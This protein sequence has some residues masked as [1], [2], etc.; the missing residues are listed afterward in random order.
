LSSQSQV[1][2]VSSPASSSGT[3]VKPKPSR[4]IGDFL[5]LK[6]L[7]QGAMGAVYLARQVSLQRDVALKVLPPELAEDQDFLE[8]F[9]REAK[10]A[11]RLN[12]PNI[13]MA[14]DVGVAEGFHYIAMELVD[15]QDLEDELRNTAQHYL[16]SAKILEIAESIAR[17]LQAA[18]R[19][20]IVHR[21]IKP[22]NILQS[23]DGVFKLADMGLAAVAGLD[24]R[25]TMAGQAVGTPYYISPEQA[26][27]EAKIDVRA[28]IYGLGATLYH[29]ATGYLPFRGETAAEVMACHIRETLEPPSEAEPAVPK[30]ISRLIEKMM[31]KLPEDRHQTPE[32]L[33]DDIE[34]VKRGEVPILKRARVKINTSVHEPISK[35]RRRRKD[36]FFQGRGMRSTVGRRTAMQ[37]AGHSR[38][39]S[40]RRRATGPLSSRRSKRNQNMYM[41]LGLIAGLLTAL[42]AGLLL[43]RFF[44]TP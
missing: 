8:R 26:L 28:D 31:A 35:P 43:H 1:E 16:A 21:D 14:Y 42:V 39:A 5:L 36:Y 13:V 22:A 32:E 24:E 33:L 27:G 40:T 9:R 6:K 19:M 15:G 11:A 38:M 37:N 4:R 18:H 29:L 34:G 20:G 7:G 2:P 23:R 25:L 3:K 30:A 44:L 12:H 41:L 10:A 17:A